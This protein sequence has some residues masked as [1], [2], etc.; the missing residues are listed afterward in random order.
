MKE[1]EG[2]ATIRETQLSRCLNQRLVDITATDTE[3]FLATDRKESQVYFHFENGETIFVV[4]R[5][6]E[7]NLGMLDMDGDEEDDEEP[8]A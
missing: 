2:L 8:E 6:G 5:T 1:E 3:E 4:L 7:Q